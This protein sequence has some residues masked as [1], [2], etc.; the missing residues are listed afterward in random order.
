MNECIIVT[1]SK[2]LER[3][4]SMADTGDVIQVIPTG[5]IFG[6]DMQHSMFYVVQ[7]PDSM[8]GTLTEFVTAW[9]DLVLAAMRAVQVTAALWTQVRAI[10]VTTELE[11]VQI[12]IDLPG[13]LIVSAGT[14]GTSWWAYNILQGVPGKLTKP[15]FKRV[16]G[17]PEGLIADG[18]VI[19]ESDPNFANA[20]TMA[21]AWGQA[22]RSTLT[23]FT[24]EDTADVTPAQ[25]AY[26]PCVVGTLPDGSRDLAR[27][28][29]IDVGILQEEV[30]SQRSRFS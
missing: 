15:G 26:M 5:T 25:D 8:I 9:I 13:E 6:K 16:A 7:N 4:T 17:I 11:D 22:L 29:V 24:L 1:H 21:E 27:F 19:N 18:G 2:Q 28:Q 20:E 30:T 12:D 14:Q 10:N 23:V 3:L